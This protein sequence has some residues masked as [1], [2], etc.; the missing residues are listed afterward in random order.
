MA[1]HAA[2]QGYAISEPEMKISRDQF[3]QRFGDR[4]TGEAEYVIVCLDSRYMPFQATLLIVSA[5]E[6]LCACLRA[7]L[8][9]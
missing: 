2:G 5:A 9:K 8:R 6:D 4:E 1:H 7:P 3:R